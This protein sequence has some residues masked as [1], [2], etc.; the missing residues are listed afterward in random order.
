[1]LQQGQ[2]LAPTALPSLAMGPAEPGPPRAPIP[3]W[4]QPCPAAMGSPWPV[5]L[6]VKMVLWPQES[7][8]LHSTGPAEEDT[9]LTALFQRVLMPEMQHLT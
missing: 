3:A 6:T 1:M 5:L 8:R 7:Q 4:P 9:S 2:S